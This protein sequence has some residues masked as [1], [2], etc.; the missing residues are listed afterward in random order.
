MIRRAYNQPDTP[1]LVATQ[2]RRTADD[3]DDDFTP[4]NSRTKGKGKPKA[5]VATV[6]AGRGAGLHTLDEHHDHL[7]L[8]TSFDGNA[9]FAGFDPSS[10]QIEPGMNFGSFTM[11]DN[12]FDGGDGMDMTFDLG[13]GEDLARE[14]GEG[15]GATHEGASGANEYVHCWNK[16]YGSIT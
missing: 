8:S 13:I 11:E 9:S 4:Q 16:P 15:W 12:L 6:E 14:L 7:L 2:R 5:S 1:F 3:D 10:S